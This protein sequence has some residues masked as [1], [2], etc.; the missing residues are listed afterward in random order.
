MKLNLW[1]YAM[2]RESALKMLQENIE[3]I[4]KFGV[5]SIGIFG[6]VARNEASEKSDLDV[7]VEYHEN[8]LNLDSYMDLKYFLQHL[9]K[10]SVD[11]VTK[12]SVKPYLK[13]KIMQ[14]VIYAA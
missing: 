14:E 2:N 7:L 12:S 9:F 5:K 6:S 3:E 8:S 13:D 10:C 4:K 11:L 1:Y